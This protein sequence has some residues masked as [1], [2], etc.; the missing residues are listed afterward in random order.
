MFKC[1]V[2]QEKDLRITELKEQIQFLK[3][4]LNPPPKVQHY[5][6][7]QDLLLEGGANEEVTP[8][9]EIDDKAEEVL[10]D[11]LAREQ[12]VLFTGNYDETE[13]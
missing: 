5:E 1:R 4:Q 13:R 11:I 9:Q 7:Q 2:C 6:L 12:D 8:E 3:N 10:N